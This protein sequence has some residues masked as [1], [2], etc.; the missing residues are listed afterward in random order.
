MLPSSPALCAATTSPFSSALQGLAVGSVAVPEAVSCGRQGCR[1]PWVLPVALSRDNSQ[2]QLSVMLGLLRSR[3]S[4]RFCCS[5]LH[6]GL[7]QP[8]EL[9]CVISRSSPSPSPSSPPP[10][11]PLLSRPSQH[12]A[13]AF[14]PARQRGGQGTRVSVLEQRR[15]GGEGGRQREKLTL[16]FI[17]F[18]KSCPLKENLVPSLGARSSQGH[19]LLTANVTLPACPAAFPEGCGIPATLCPGMAQRCSRYFGKYFG[20]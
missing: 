6:S 1:I 3:C 14:I 9:F 4:T 15:E 19:P 5:L 20:V 8:P 11:P 17:M 18:P 7:Q 16:A 13:P 2:L 10:P 12:P